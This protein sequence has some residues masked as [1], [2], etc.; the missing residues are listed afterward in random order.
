MAL[1]YDAANPSRSFYGTDTRAHALLIGAALAVLL[2]SRPALLTH[3]RARA[4]A[5]LSGPLIALV[6]LAAFAT[7]GEESYFYY[8]GG[9]AVFA[10]AVAAALWAIEAVPRSIPGSVLS[11]APLRWVGTVS[12][13]LYLWHWPIGIWLSDSSLGLADRPR[14]VLEIALTFGAATASFYLVEWPVRRGA[15]PWLRLSR[16][17]LAVVAPVAL[18]IV[19]GLALESTNAGSPVARQIADRSDSPCP[20]GSPMARSTDFSWCS[21]TA[22]AGP[23]S[24]V[25]ATVGDS[26]SRALDPGMRRLA[27]ARGWRYIQAGAFSCTVLPLT[28]P[29]TGSAS[30][31]AY[32]RNCRRYFPTVRA[33]VTAAYHPDIWIVSD[34]YPLLPVLQHGGTF[35]RQDDPGWATIVET[36]MRSSFQHLTAYGARVV[37]VAPLPT[38]EPV[39]CSTQR[40]APR[41]CTSVKYTTADP[42][43]RTL[44]D[45]YRRVSAHFPGKVA[46]VSI[47][48][49]LC[50]RGRCPAVIDGRVARADT[51][52]FT[53]SFSR[54]IVPVIVARAERAGI[55]FTRSR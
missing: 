12:Y 50:P 33:Q 6:V 36:A 52:H 43:V 7:V 8:H 34:A 25:V 45:V 29:R 48:D 9:A 27:K 30:G 47:A 55:A 4:A 1:L 15:V 28:I 35:L 10:L 49:V 14:Q 3:A 16:T 46:D 54:R 17:R 44:N 37:I 18:A 13:G 39:E 20:P 31:I 2:W 26:T 38:G 51:L 24:A 23:D 41:S 22:P 53:A 32:A 40:P 5:T 11:W 19:A 21:R 42:W